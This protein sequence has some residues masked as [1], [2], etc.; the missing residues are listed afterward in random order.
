MLHP[1]DIHKIQQFCS[2][3]TEIAAAYLFGSSAT[4]KDRSKSD[5]DLVIFN[6]GSAL[7]QHQILKYGKLVYKVAPK[8]G[9]RQEVFARKAYFD[10]AFFYRKIRPESAHGGH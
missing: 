4:G 5:M 2:E 1:N 8:E 3:Y 10:S 9:V 7:L 6:Q